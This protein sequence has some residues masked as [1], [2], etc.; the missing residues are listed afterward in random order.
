[1]RGL[2][3]HIPFCIK[4]CDYC[5]FISF[6]DCYNREWEYLNALVQEF[7]AYEDKAVD[8]VYIALPNHLHFTYAKEA[9]ERGKHVILEKPA[10]ETAAKRTAS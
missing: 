3:I 8:T 5:D 2:Y 4:K 1:M 7:R 6:S 10:T 9:L